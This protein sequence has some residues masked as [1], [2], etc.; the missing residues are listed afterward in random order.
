MSYGT[1][2]PAREEQLKQLAERTAKFWT[3]LVAELTA[4]GRKVDVN[5]VS[6]CVVSVDGVG[7]WI[8]VDERRKATSGRFRIGSGTGVLYVSFNIDGGRAYTAPEGKSGFNI[9]KVADALLAQVDEK[10][11]ERVLEKRQD[12]QRKLA[13]TVVDDINAEL[14]LQKY[15]GLRAERDRNG[16][17]GIAGALTPAEVRAAL[18]LIQEMRK[19]EG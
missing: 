11:R 10:L 13:E 9:K 19:A 2:S 6:G 7:T 1:P 12:E 17:L 5:D 3:D 4:R 14:G 8:R 18:K 16:S 15:T